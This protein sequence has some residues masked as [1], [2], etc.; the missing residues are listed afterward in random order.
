M[1]WKSEEGDLGVRKQGADNVVDNTHGTG[2]PI[3]FIKERIRNGIT[4]GTSQRFLLNSIMKDR[5]SL[6][7]TVY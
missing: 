2:F 1:K 5:T 6:G 4:E 7:L 3:A